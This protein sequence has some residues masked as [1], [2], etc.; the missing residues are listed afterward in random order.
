[1][2]VDDLV[3]IYTHLYDNSSVITRDVIHDCSLLMY[4]ERSLSQIIIGFITVA[5][6]HSSHHIVI[7]VIRIFLVAK[8][9][10]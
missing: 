2:P 5:S 3:N 10:Q 8:Q 1:M 9:R 6:T 4:L 7:S